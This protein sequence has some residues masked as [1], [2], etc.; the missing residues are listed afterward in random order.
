MAETVAAV[1]FAGVVT[2]AV[3][4]GAD[5]GCGIWDLTA[6][7]GRRGQTVRRHID[8]S[9]GPVWEANHVWLIFVLVMLWTGFPTAFTAIITTL[10]VPWALAGLGIIL[11]GGAF[12]F[13]KSSPTFTQ[14]RMH[15]IVFATASII[16]PFFLGAIAGAIASGRVDLEASDDPLYA[17]TGPLSLVG[18]TLAVLVTAFLAATLLATA[19]HRGGDDDLADYFRCRAIVAGAVTGAAALAAA[20]TI[21]SSAPALADGL[22]GPGAPLIALSTVGGTT[23]LLA[24]RQRRFV[25]ARLAAATA[26]ASMV[27]GWGVAQYPDILIGA[28]TIDEAAGAEP[29]LRALLVV[30]A[31]AAVIVVPPLIWLLRLADQPPRPG[32]TPAGKP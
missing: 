17:W 5:Y 21:E 10:A 27:V 14:A 7:S 22:H 8:A 13:R 16:T 2:Y 26:V 29:T 25:L 11:R 23:A 4:G 3:L 30:S 20:V 18:G 12:V 6:G 32:Q 19:A 15:G 9:I 28:A 24:L 1:M 31:A